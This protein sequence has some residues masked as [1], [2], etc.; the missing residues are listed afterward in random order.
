[1]P[2]TQC[3]PHAPEHETGPST[4]SAA[5]TASAPGCCSPYRTPAAHR[6]P[7]NCPIVW[8]PCE[9]RPEPKP[10]ETPAPWLASA[11]CA[12]LHLGRIE[13]AP[14]PRNDAFLQRAIFESLPARL[15]IGQV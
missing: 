9:S 10:P 1:M 12:G 11:R 7:G 15:P 13:P 14:F 2:A 3:Q 8:G 6:P 5:A 4:L